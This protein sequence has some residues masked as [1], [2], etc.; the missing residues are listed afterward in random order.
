MA[1]RSGVDKVI[2]RAMA[3]IALAG[4]SELEEARTAAYQ[5]CALIRGEKLR[6]L[7][8]LSDLEPN[9]GL[10]PGEIRPRADGSVC[11]VCGEPFRATAMRV[12]VPGIGVGERKWA[13]L[14]CAARKVDEFTDTLASLAGGGKKPRKGRR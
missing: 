7:P 14:T 9:I 10:E 8:P 4:S 13:H 1:E 11:A 12:P 5:A 2:D 3:L 6:L